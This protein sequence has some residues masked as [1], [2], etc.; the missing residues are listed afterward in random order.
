MLGISGIDGHIAI[1]QVGDSVLG[2]ACSHIGGLIDAVIRREVCDLIIRRID[3]NPGDTVHL[4]L[5]RNLR[6]YSAISGVRI[7]RHKNRVVGNDGVN[8][9]GVI[10]SF[11]GSG[12]RVPA[13]ALARRCE[14]PVA[15][16]GP[17]YILS[18]SVQRAD[19]LLTRRNEMFRSERIHA[20]GWE[21]AAGTILIK[22]GRANQ[23]LGSWSYSRRQPGNPPNILPIHG[24]LRHTDICRSDI[25]MG[26]IP[27]M[28]A[29]PLVAPWHEWVTEDNAVVLRSC[30]H[31]PVPT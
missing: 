31:R 4:M 15:N 6:P 29:I 21:K 2:P 11:N 17:Y 25:V 23:N 14:R 19:H 28:N 9:I 22:L 18:R 24:E 12:D 13:L 20:E 7:L 5:L 1:D 26:G 3:R 27:A 8:D 16:P 10:W 30:N